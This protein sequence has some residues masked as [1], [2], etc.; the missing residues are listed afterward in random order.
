MKIELKII[1]DQ[2]TEMLSLGKNSQVA[3]CFKSPESEELVG[4]TII[5]KDAKTGDIT[6][7]GK[8]YKNLKELMI[9]N[10]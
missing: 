4:W 10:I 1:C 9:D 7:T 2:L 5:S 6:T 3:A 8:K